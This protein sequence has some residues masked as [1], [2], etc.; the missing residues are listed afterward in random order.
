MKRSLSTLAVLV[1]ATSSSPAVLVWTLG[2]SEVAGRQA[3]EISSLYGVMNPVTFW[4]E[5]NAA[6]DALPGSPASPG[7]NQQQDDDFYFE[8]IYNNQVDGGPAY[9]LAGV[10]ANREENLERAVTNGDLRNRFHFNFAGTHNA[11]DTFTVSFGMLDLNDNSTGTGQ[12]DFA[13]N[14]NGVNVGNVS[15]TSATIGTMFTSNPF[16]LAD[17]GATAGAPDDNYVELVAS[18]PG[19]TARWSNF[20]YIRMDYTPVPEPR[21]SVLVL[22]SSVLFLGILRRRIRK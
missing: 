15:H 10:V 12:Y 1:L 6:G 11:A 22:V 17:V 20:D 13:I 21:S 18:N 14:V 16:T 3:P 9:A 8:G 7:G 2:N 4:Q 5:N 19:S